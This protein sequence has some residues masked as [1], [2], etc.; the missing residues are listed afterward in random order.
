MESCLSGW[1]CADL[2]D[3][4]CQKAVPKKR[5]MSRVNTNRM[6]LYS[7]QAPQ[8]ASGETLRAFATGERRGLR[9]PGPGAVPGED[10]TIGV[11][12]QGLPCASQRW[13]MFPGFTTNPRLTPGDRQYTDVFFHS[14]TLYCARRLRENSLGNDSC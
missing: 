8:A 14:M 13:A 2:R 7:A 10:V 3:P 6:E 9:S 4:I 5:A 1:L 12:M 11:K